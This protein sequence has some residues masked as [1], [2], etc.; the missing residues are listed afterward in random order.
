[1]RISFY[2]PSDWT[3]IITSKIRDKLKI[4]KVG[5]AKFIL[6]YSQT[7]YK[8]EEHIPFEF[9]RKLNYKTL[10]H[11]FCNYILND[12]EFTM[13]NNII[14]ISNLYDGVQ[15]V[16]DYL[17]LSDK[18]IGTLILA[19]ALEL[20]VESFWIKA[21]QGEFKIND[22]DEMKSSLR[23]F[24]SFIDPNLELLFD[25]DEIQKKIE[26]F[27]SVYKDD[28]F[29]HL[30]A[31]SIIIFKLNKLNFWIP[32]RFAN[33]IG[34]Q[35]IALDFDNSGEDTIHN[36]ILKF[37]DHNVLVNIQKC[38]H[39]DALLVN[40][41]GIIKEMFSALKEEYYFVVIITCLTIVDYLIYE[42]VKSANPITK[43]NYTN[44]GVIEEMLKIIESIKITMKLSNFFPND[45][46]FE[47]GLRILQ[48]VTL[49]N[50]LK[51]E[52]FSSSDR[53]EKNE[54]EILNRHGI[55]HGKLY[56]FGTRENA[57][58]IIILID[59]LL[60]FYNHYIKK[61]N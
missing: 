9:F 50:Y 58:R 16:I 34:K 12:K 6:Y 8:K 28:F 20:K 47:N 27:S 48:L 39:E 37:Y 61:D 3:V 10:D 2:K 36:G 51:K 41:I 7:E 30:S 25:N 55:L 22:S 45:A 32:S 15:K 56:N 13:E 11:L 54:N 57:Y 44:L 1:M 31:I 26:E 59:D 19:L 5:L 33:E 21:L 60:F 29:E 24:K 23:K 52:V 35:I 40:R 38:W 4:N 42:I 46:N 49:T 18:K 17:I 53:F 43:N 14:G